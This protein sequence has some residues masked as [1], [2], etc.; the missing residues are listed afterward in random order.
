M[1]YSVCTQHLIVDRN[2]EIWQNYIQFHFLS[3]LYFCINEDVL[4]THD[5]RY[6]NQPC[7]FL[8]TKEK[9]LNPSISRVNLHGKSIR[10]HKTWF[11][12]CY[13]GLCYIDT[14]G[15]IKDPSLKSCSSSTSK[16]QQPWPCWLILSCCGKNQYFSI[17]I[18]SCPNFAIKLF[19]CPDAK[20]DIFVILL[21]TVT[22]YV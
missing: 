2:W 9:V 18:M 7:V 15:R 10:D 20:C 14:E 21:I 5:W 19:R 4:C 17:P 6:V 8:L 1:V 22:L 16:S 13:L 3:W 11:R 12:S